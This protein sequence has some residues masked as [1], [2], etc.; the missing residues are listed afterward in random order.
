MRARELESERDISYLKKKKKKFAGP[1]VM[2]EN[3][4]IG[5]FFSFFWADLWWCFPNIAI[6]PYKTRTYIGV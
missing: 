4:T 5:L 6:G 3:A 2:F 1:I